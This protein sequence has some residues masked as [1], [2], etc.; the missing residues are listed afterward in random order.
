MEL[1]TIDPTS[2]PSADQAEDLTAAQALWRALERDTQAA[3]EQ[4]HRLEL[5]KLTSEEHRLL[6]VWN[7]HLH[8]GD[9][10][11]ITPEAHFETRFEIQAQPL[12]CTTCGKPS[13]GIAM[14]TDG[15]PECV[16]AFHQP[17]P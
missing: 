17:Q 6:W 15:T 10:A 5:V 7:D 13:T 12:L 4:G 2:A 14:R 8:N 9:R 11:G 3:L 1:I 16:D